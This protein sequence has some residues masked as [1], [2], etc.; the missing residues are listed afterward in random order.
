MTKCNQ[1]PT[2]ELKTLV[3]IYLPPE[4][5]TYTVPAFRLELCHKKQRCPFSLATEETQ[6]G[7]WRLFTLTGWM[8]RKVRNWMPSQK[9]HLGFFVVMIGSDWQTE[10][11]MTIVMS[12]FVTFSSLDWSAAILCSRPDPELHTHISVV[13]LKFS[14]FSVVYSSRAPQILCVDGRMFQV[15]PHCCSSPLWDL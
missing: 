12:H 6:R 4:L 14:L 7:S 5:V 3:N 9:Y 2:K 15:S 8:W 11:I 1:N 13:I 10:A